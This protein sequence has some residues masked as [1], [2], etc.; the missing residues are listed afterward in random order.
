MKELTENLAKMSVNNYYQGGRYLE[1]L[2]Y[3]I[4]IPINYFREL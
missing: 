1:D 3:E 2:S 4:A